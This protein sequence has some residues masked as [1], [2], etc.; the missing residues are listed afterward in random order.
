MDLALE[1]QIQI[2]EG[3]LLLIPIDCMT[4][5]LPFL[6]VTR[7]SMSTVSLLA[8][9]NSGILYLYMLSFDL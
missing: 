4:F 3:G 2:L 5:L 8:Q 7:M 9:L 1:L 6:D